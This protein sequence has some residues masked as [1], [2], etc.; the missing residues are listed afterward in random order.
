MLLA[1]VNV[2]GDDLVIQYICDV[3][4]VDYEEIK[5]KLPDN[6]AAKVQEVQDVLDGIVP[7]DESG[8]MGE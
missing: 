3:L 6:E 4:D 1:L 7:D 5:D 2:F 8:G